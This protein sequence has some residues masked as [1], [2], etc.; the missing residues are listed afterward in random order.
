MD[1]AILI[2]ELEIDTD[3]EITYEHCLYLLERHRRSGSSALAIKKGD[4]GI[5]RTHITHT[6]VPSDE[7]K[8]ILPVKVVSTF[9]SKKSGFYIRVETTLRTGKT[10]ISMCDK[11]YTPL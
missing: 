7:E 3:I 6:L 4:E 11:Y 10:I 8:S 9:P 2:S 5:D 1:Y